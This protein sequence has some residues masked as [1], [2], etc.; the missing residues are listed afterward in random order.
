MTL[1]LIHALL[2]SLILLLA[3]TTTTTSTTTSSNNSNIRAHDSAANNNVKLS[4][5]SVK[6]QQHLEALNGGKLG[7][8]LGKTGGVAGYL[9]AE[10]TNEELNK[11]DALDATLANILGRTGPDMRP[12]RDFEDFH[13]ISVEVAKRAWRLMHQHA[14]SAVRD[15]FKLM[16]PL[17][18]QALLAANVSLDCMKAAIDT[19]SAAQ[20]LDSWAIQRKLS[21]LKLHQ[22]P[23]TEIAI[24][25]ALLYLTKLNN[26]LTFSKPTTQQSTTNNQ[27]LF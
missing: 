1:C 23:T 8:S 19:M 26:K 5:A 6:P 9:L 27:Q 16:G 3:S 2:T 22:L 25:S 4:A 14:K 20:R 17:V 11:S 10:A 21:T 13:D 15:R 24:H 18:E 7:D 12:M